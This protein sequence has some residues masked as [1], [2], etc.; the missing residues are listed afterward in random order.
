MR[1]RV[2]AFCSRTPCK[3]K[4]F[5]IHSWN[6]TEKNEDILL[7]EYG[8]FSTKGEYP[9]ITEGKDYEL[10]LELISS[11][12]KWGGTYKIIS[13]PSIESIDFKELTR[14]ESF[15]ILMECTSSEKIA[16]NILNAY[17]DFIDLVMTQGKDVIDTKKIHGVGDVYLTAYIRELTNKYKYYHLMQEFKEYMVDVTD[18]KRL[19][20]YYKDLESISSALETNPYEVLIEI[21]ERSF[22]SADKLIMEIKPE[23]KESLIRCEALLISVIEKNE[24]EGSTRLNANDLYFFIKDEY[25]FP[26]LIPLIVPTVKSGSRIYY[27]EKSKDVAKMKTYQAEQYIAMFIREKDKNSTKL[28]FDCSKYTTVGEFEMS[29]KQGSMLNLFC[30]N[31]FSMLVGFSGSGKTTSIQ[32]IIKMLESEGLTY[33]LLAPTGKA[34]KRMS[35]ATHRDAST[36]HRKVIRDKEIWNDVVIVDESSMVD[37]GTFTMLLKSI[38]NPYVRIILVGDPAQLLPVGIG[39][40]FNDII[41]SG[42]VPMVMLDE[43]FRYNSSGSLYVATNVRQG[44]PFFDK[45]DPLVKNNGKEVKVGS[46]YR[47]IQSENIFDDV[48]REYTNLIKK[49]IKPKNILCLSPFNVGEEGSYNINNVIQSEINPPKPKESIMT[50]LVDRDRTQITFRLGDQILNK[51]ND[52]SALP[53]E[54]W[55]MIQENPNLLTEDDVPL[56]SIFNGQEGVIVD[57]DENKIIAQFDEELV[58]LSKMKVKDLLLSNCISVHSSQGSEAEYVINVVSPLH[59]RMLNRNLLYVADTRSKKSQI[60]IGDMDTYNAALLVDGNAERDT[61]LKELLLDEYRN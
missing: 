1:M 40:V 45:N 48:L 16:N 12:K 33:C 42:V 4:D 39:C 41:N 32:G 5:R 30:E 3:N 54:S 6:L 53:Y 13:V 38:K 19:V 24:E 61:F 43:I 49:G 25:N 14:E 31:S 56:T 52:Y 47:F 22:N 10:E 28:E 8:T 29:A 35:E 55:Q 18:C 37:L 20:S 44:E 59:S 34:A 51:K 60:D 57:I 27:D 7:S 11:S 2:K 15:E 50:K 36:I 23:L 58:V 21:L 9:F 17:P 26:E 46:N